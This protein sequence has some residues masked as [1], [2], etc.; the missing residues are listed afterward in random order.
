MSNQNINVINDINN[1]IKHRKN[2]LVKLKRNIIPYLDKIKINGIRGVFDSFL[3]WNS[4]DDEDFYEDS[5]TLST[6][7]SKKKIF[8]KYPARHLYNTYDDFLSGYENDKYFFVFKQKYMQ[9][10]RDDK[11]SILDDVKNIKIK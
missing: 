8:S 9:T 7:A 2:E 6:I 4:S 1:N 11:F 3:E 10:L 5:S